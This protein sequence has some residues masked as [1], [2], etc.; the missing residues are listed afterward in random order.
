MI[1]LRGFGTKPSIPFE[2]VERL[3][4]TVAQCEIE[5]FNVFDYPRFRDGFG[6]SDKPTLHLISQQNLS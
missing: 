1:N 4:L 5:D 6:N 2:A 3:H